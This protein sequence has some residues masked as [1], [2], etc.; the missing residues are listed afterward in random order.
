[1]KKKI[2]VKAKR[3]TTV[4][5]QEVTRLGALLRSLGSLGGSAA[6]TLVGQP[7]MGASIGNSLGASLSKWLGSGDY[8]VKTNS[9]IKNNTNGIP[10]MHNTG[11]SIVVRHK[12]FISTIVGTTAFTNQGNFY[13]NP[14]L[15]QSFPWLSRLA[16]CYQQYKIRG[17][18]YHYVPTSGN[19]V[20]S[21]N[22]ALG[23]VMMQ[24]TYR[25]NDT[26]PS[27]KLELLNEF[28]SNESVPSESFCHPIECNPTENPFQIHYVRTGAVPASDSPL[29][30]DVGRLFVAT[31]GMPASNNVVGD[32][33]CSYEIELLKPLVVSNVTSTFTTSLYAKDVI[34]ANITTTNLFG[35]GAINAHGGNLTVTYAPAGIINIPAA[36]AGNYVIVVSW[37]AATVFT[38]VDMSAKTIAYTNCSAFNAQF[39]TAYTGQSISGVGSQTERAYIVAGITVVAIQD[40]SVAIGG[41]SFIG[42]FNSSNV[43]IYYLG[44]DF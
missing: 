24:T 19:A 6:G 10:M 27:S 3:P 36:Q 22:P 29:M 42:S 28:F 30:Y 17:M 2:K 1:V 7:A 31:Q 25:S 43:A 14:G 9:L 41:M 26:Q 23:A 20:S 34:S 16:V 33:W 4:A 40:V 13:I 39:G 21:T 5:K 38:V 18:V 12:E 35:T 8:T 37:L 11:T 32:L 15:T 44:P